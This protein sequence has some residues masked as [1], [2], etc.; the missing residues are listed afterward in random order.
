MSCLPEL[1]RAQDCGAGRAEGEPPDV[2]S[3]DPRSPLT[4]GGVELGTL[5]W[6]VVIIALPLAL[7]LFADTRGLFDR[8]G[9]GAFSI[10]EL[11]PPP[12]ASPPAGAV[13]KA[14]RELEIRQLVQARND[15][16][17]ARGEPAIDVEAETCK[18][19]ALDPGSDCGDRPTADAELREE[20]RGLVIARNERRI[21]RGESPLDVEAE[22]DRQLRDAGA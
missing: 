7:V 6:I 1:A 5:I 22:I 12:G 17:L 13:S 8:I 20:V 21:A 16:R 18:L 3:G 11:R 2:Q 19:L 9:G 14:E 4:L 15:R 10:E